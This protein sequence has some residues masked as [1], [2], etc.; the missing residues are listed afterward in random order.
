[1][2]KLE[3]LVQNSCKNDQIVINSSFIDQLDVFRELTLVEMKIIESY[4]YHNFKIRRSNF[5]YPFYNSIFIQNIELYLPDNEDV[6][7]YLGKS[8]KQLEREAR[9]TT[10]HYS[11]NVS[12]YIIGPVGN[13]YYHKL[14]QFNDQENLSNE[15]ATGMYRRGNIYRFNRFS[16]QIFIDL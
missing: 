5:Y 8:G 15:F 10:V 7:F 1:M 12:Y 9:V 16:K 14:S 11:F 13:P 2:P 3:K 6:L 4:V